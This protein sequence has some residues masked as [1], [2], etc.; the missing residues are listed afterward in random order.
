MKQNS[1]RRVKSTVLLLPL[2]ALGMVSGAEAAPPAVDFAKDIRPIFET[3]CNQCHG[4]E[5]QMNGLRLD[6]RQPAFEGGESGPAILP[7]N[8]AGS[9][10]Y[11]KLLGEAEG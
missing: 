2:A 10:L 8:S 9:L 5:K 1:A 4:S 7:G 11:R 3:K 6:T